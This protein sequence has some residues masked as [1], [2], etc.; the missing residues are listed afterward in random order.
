MSGSIAFPLVGVVLK[1][2]LLSHR[3]RLGVNYNQLPVNAPVAPVANFQ[4]DGAMTFI[5]QG[6][7]PN[8]QSSLVPLK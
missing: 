4:R 8:Y 5:S 3:H 2:I 1:S 7:R 6:A